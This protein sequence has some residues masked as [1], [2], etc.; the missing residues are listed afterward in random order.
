MTDQEKRDISYIIMT[1]A[2]KSQMSL[3][4]EKKELNRAGDRVSHVHPLRFLLYIFSDGQLKTAV[5][6]IKGLPWNRFVSGMAG[7]LDK[8]AAR[9][10]IKEEYVADFS[11]TVG[12]D[13][14]ILAPSL[15]SR[16]WEEFINIVRNH[17]P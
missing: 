15:Q 12:V 7:S 10:S 11:K 5:K 8:A 13:P 14:S 2:T 1:L 6:K 4:F 3:L 17:L 16:H 9:N